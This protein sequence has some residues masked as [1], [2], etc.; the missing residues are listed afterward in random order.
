[1]KEMWN[2]R[3]AKDEY[4][5][6]KEPNVF[7]A[8][9]LDKLEPGKI[10][11][12]GEG[13]G[14][15]AVH[16]AKLGWDVD[17]YDYSIEAKTKALKFAGDEAVKINY[18]VHDLNELVPEKNIYDAVVIVFLHLPE[19]QRIRLHKNIVNSLKPSGK[20]ILEVFDKTQI[21]R[22]SGGPKNL[23]LLYSLEDIFEDFQDLEIISF[24]KEEVQLNEG[25]F[26]N[27]LASVIRYVG[28]KQKTI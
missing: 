10:L 25:P 24:S 15:N 4:V 28:Q 27:G 19:E 9:Q 7:Y 3:Y 13:E 5:Y 2:D 26:H 6:G 17:A 11:F 18:V 20:I 14:R 22:N 21:E 1:M 16:A 8:A 23:E 12:L